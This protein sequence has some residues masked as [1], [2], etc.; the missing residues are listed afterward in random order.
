[1]A[2]PNIPIRELHIVPCRL[3][4]EYIGD[5]VDHKTL[6]KSMQFVFLHSGPILWSMEETP[7]SRISQAEGENNL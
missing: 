4:A 6:E 5:P 3:T 7:Q 1:M 2:L